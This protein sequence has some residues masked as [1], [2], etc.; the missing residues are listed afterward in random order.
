MRKL[1]VNIENKS[2]DIIIRNDFKDMLAY[3]KEVYQ[4]KKIFIITDETVY[5]LHYESLYNL[6]KDD[7]IVDYVKINAGEKSKDIETYQY[8]CEELIKKNIRRNE[9]II[10]LG[11]GVIGDISAF[12]ASTLYRGLNFINIPTT[13]LSMVDSSIG[14]KTGIDFLGQKNILGTFYQPKLV[15]INLAYLKTLPSDEVKSGMGELIKHGMIGDPSLLEDL[16][17]GEE[18]SEDIIHSSLLVKKEVVE[19]DPYDQKERM[20]LNFG[21][22]FGHVIELKYN[23]K[24]GIAVAIGMLM[25]LKLGIDLELTDPSCYKI[26]ESTLNNYGF[27]T[28]AY[29]Y[30]EFLN[31]IKKDKKNLAGKL[32]FVLIKDIGKPFLYT[33]NENEIEDLLWM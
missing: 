13:L 9:L 23:L 8:I 21:H 14:G 18:V 17:S 2:Y 3:I 32:N 1:S 26:L 33:V 15:L 31:E 12:V 6:L 30:H 29:D 22:T 28:K 27:D 19:K 16:M 4:N 11:G 24:H 25:A 20:F 10:A 7:Y 5:N